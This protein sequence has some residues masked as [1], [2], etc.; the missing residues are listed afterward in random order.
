MKGNKL[1]PNH[2]L[3]HASR[4]RID[5]YITRPDALGSFP[6]RPN[7]LYDFTQELFRDL[8]CDGRNDID[9]D[10]LH[11]EY[12]A[13]FGHPARLEACLNDFLHNWDIA[14]ADEYSTHWLSM[15][16]LAL[17]VCPVHRQDY[18]ACFDDDEDGCDQIRAFF[19]SHDT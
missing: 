18:A 19:P 10:A 2:A 7:D 11:T 13:V 9:L 5:A 6:Y 15:H 17:S 16:C 4:L 14:A 8:L 1:M 12:D 3:A